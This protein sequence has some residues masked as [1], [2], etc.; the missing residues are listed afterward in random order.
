[1][2]KRG[3]LISIFAIAIFVLASCGSTSPPKS[4]KAGEVNN[5]KDTV[6]KSDKVI[7]SSMNLNDPLVIDFKKAQL[8]HIT[9]ASE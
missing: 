4:D 2:N 1:M 6:V 7:L 3:A 8:R 9:N 5:Q